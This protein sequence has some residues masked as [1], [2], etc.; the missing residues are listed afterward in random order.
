MIEIRDEK[1][2]LIGTVPGE[3]PALKFCG[4]Y[5]LVT[6]FQNRI[7]LEGCKFIVGGNR[8]Y[9]LLC[10]KGLIERVSKVDGF[11]PAKHDSTT[12]I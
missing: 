4:M 7:E 5:S 9:G 11:T 6:G 10:P 12:K 1:T 8:V 3:L 2:N